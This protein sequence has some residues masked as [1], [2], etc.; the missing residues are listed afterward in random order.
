MNREALRA[1]VGKNIES[2]LFPTQM[3]KQR[4][5]GG[6]GVPGQIQFSSATSHDAMYKH[7]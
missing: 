2:K 5:R 3:M 1:M 7:Q 6:D 4:S